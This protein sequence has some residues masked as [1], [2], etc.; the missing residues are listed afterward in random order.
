[1]LPY[2]SFLTAVCSPGGCDLDKSYDGPKLTHSED[3]YSISLDFIKGMLEWYKAGK[4][5]PKRLVSLCIGRMSL[6]HGCSIFRY[7]WE[8]VLGAHEA[9]IKEESLVT[10]RLEEGMTC[11]VIGDVHG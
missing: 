11:D 6:D 5:L 9:F 2:H 3:G 1:M 10:I 8:I 4:S 7:V